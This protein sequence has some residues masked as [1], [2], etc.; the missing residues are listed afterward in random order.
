MRPD[1]KREE[2][3][4]VHRDNI[5]A[6]RRPRLSPETENQLVQAIEG[7]HRALQPEDYQPHE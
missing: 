6:I 4:R 3:W 1:K 7:L 5:E 2:L